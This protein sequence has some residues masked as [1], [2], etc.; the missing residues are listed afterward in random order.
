MHSPRKLRLNSSDARMKL[1]RWKLNSELDSSIWWSGGISHAGIWELPGTPEQGTACFT[2]LQ[3]EVGAQ[4][5]AIAHTLLVLHVTRSYLEISHFMGEQTLLGGFDAL[6]CSSPNLEFRELSREGKS[7]ILSN[8][9]HLGVVIHT[10]LEEIEY[11]FA[12]KC[13]SP[14]RV[15]TSFHG[16]S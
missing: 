14:F 5:G 6:W 16:F 12:L 8:F 2:Q 15:L 10:V 3:T 1:F 9:T 11:I 13:S 4:C 7:A